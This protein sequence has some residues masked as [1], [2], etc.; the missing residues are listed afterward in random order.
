LT[1]AAGRVF[2]SAFLVSATSVDNRLIVPSFLQWTL[3]WL[4][5]ER[6][7]DEIAEGLLRL[8]PIMLA[9]Y[10]M[11]L[12]MVRCRLN[13]RMSSPSPTRCQSSAACVMLVCR[14]P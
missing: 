9:P 3:D 13:A 7:G 5:R 4:R 12:T 14:R 6:A 8:L 10:I 11:S 2:S 1:K